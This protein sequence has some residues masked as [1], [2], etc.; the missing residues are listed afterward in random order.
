MFTHKFF[1]FIRAPVSFQVPVALM[2]NKT[3]LHL[4]C[5]SLI[6][7]PRVTTTNFGCHWKLENELGLF[8][9]E[10]QKLFFVCT[11]SIHSDFGIKRILK[12]KVISLLPK[13]NVVNHHWKSHKNHFTKPFI[14][15]EL[16][17]FSDAMCQKSNDRGDLTCTAL[18]NRTFVVLTMSKSD[19]FVTVAW[20][21]YKEQQFWCLEENQVWG[22]V[23][24]YSMNHVI[25][26]HY[27]NGVLSAD[28]DVKSFCHHTRAR[29]IILNFL[30]IQTTGPS[31][32]AVIA[33][34]IWVHK[35]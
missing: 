11:H 28:S 22:N 24:G 15:L 12:Q 21:L 34:C 25:C 30:K 33:R 19:L 17:Y 10:S 35:F 31:T 23:M 6:I 4:D 26:C 20:S 5:Q 14:T 27:V 3:P 32:L 2:L 7:R 13:S 8:P 9:Q 18:Q 1:T 29:T 16:V